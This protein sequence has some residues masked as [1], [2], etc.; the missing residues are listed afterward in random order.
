MQQ[1]SS[2]QA[3]QN[4]GDLMK[5]ASEAPVAIERHGR[6]EAIIAAP[7]FFSPLGEQDLMA[8]KQARLQ[9]TL[10]EKD[11]LVRH[12]RIALDLVTATPKERAAMIAQ[13]LKVVER[14]RQERLC[15]DDY[16]DRWSAILRKPVREMALTMISD[17]EGW[18]TA[19]RQNSP[20]V[21]LHA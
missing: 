14:W 13:A 2:T 15:S 5:A 4:F 20:W 19:L 21:G 12:Q 8:R 11:R 6:V 7:R 1:F 9:Q 3:K 16:I 18:G 17:A 10:V